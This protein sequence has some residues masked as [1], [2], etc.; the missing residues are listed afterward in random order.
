MYYYLHQQIILGE[1][2]EAFQGLRRYE[3]IHARTYILVQQ[4]A[5]PV[6]RDHTSPSPG[7]L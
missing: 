6:V 1:I 2:P 5:R 4:Q 3:Y 7:S